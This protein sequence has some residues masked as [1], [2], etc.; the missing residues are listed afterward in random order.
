[1]PQFALAGIGLNRHPTSRR[2]VMDVNLHRR[3]I[4]RVPPGKQIRN[5]IGVTRLAR[6][7]S[8]LHQHCQ[9]LEHQLCPV[10]R[11]PAQLVQPLD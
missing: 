11:H 9:R 3:P 8:D 10:G 4:R 2:F 1:M 5:A 7:L 6:S